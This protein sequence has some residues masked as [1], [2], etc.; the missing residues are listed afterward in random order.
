MVTVMIVDDQSDVRMGIMEGL[1]A[2]SK[3]YKFVEVFDA[4]NCIEELGRVTPDILLIDIMMP[5]VN[6]IEL[7]S[8][9]HRIEQIRNVPIIFITAVDDEE[10]LKIAAEYSAHIV[11]KPFEI[12]KLHELIFSLTK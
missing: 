5:K 2:L 8:E 7:V 4:D 6:G 3:G 1:K 12:E 10:V 9:I 11:K